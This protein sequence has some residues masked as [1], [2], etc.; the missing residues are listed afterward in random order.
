MEIAATTMATK[1][2]KVT[3]KGGRPPSAEGPMLLQPF[4]MPAELAERID[5]EAD[6]L[7]AETPGL[8]LSRSETIRILIERALASVQ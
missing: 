5:R 6:R 3:G 2:R 8:S 4:R 1:R 7:R